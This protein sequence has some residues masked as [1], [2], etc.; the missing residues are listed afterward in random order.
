[1]GGGSPLL[2]QPSGDPAKEE[3]GGSEEAFPTPGWLLK[4]RLPLPQEPLS[5]ASWGTQ[6]PACLLAGS[7]GKGSRRGGLRHP[8]RPGVGLCIC[9]SCS[10]QP[11]PPPLPPPPPLR[12]PE[13]LPRSS[14]SGLAGGLSWVPLAFLAGP[15]APGT[16]PLPHPE[17]PASRRARDSTQPGE[18][19][20]WEAGTR[21]AGPWERNQ[22]PPRVLWN[23][24]AA[25]PDWLLWSCC[26]DCS[27][28]QEDTQSPGKWEWTGL[29]SSSGLKGPFCS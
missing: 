27:V 23:P 25:S 12:W 14:S 16:T 22:G 17:W 11:L 3:G 6:N 29:P 24:G 5:W 28:R 2:P 21:A 15:Q 10:Q 13:P 7:P 9:R 4:P 19:G 8:A 18:L 26:G 20:R 1:M